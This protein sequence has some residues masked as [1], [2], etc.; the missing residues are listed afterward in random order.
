M[1]GEQIVSQMWDW[2]PRQEVGKD[3]SA[4]RHR[5][6]I[7]V[8]GWNIRSSAINFHEDKWLWSARDRWQQQGW[9]LAL[10]CRTALWDVWISQDDGR[11]EIFRSLRFD[12]LQIISQTV[13]QYLGTKPVFCGC[14]SI[15][16]PKSAAVTAQPCLWLQDF[17]EF[18]R[19]NKVQ[20]V[21]PAWIELYD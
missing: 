5:R 7:T 13:S 4:S 3:G 14:S 11:E 15:Y 1:S 2:K 6:W 20:D 9:V 17:P 16:V 21:S 10:L 19:S 12:G 8:A 18:Y